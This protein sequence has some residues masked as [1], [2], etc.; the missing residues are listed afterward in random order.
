MLA[1]VIEREDFVKLRTK[2]IKKTMVAS[3]NLMLLLYDFAWK[4]DR[5]IYTGFNF[6]KYQWIYP[7]SYHYLRITRMLRS[8]NLFGLKYYSSRFLKALEAVYRQYPNQIGS[9]IDYWRAA[10][11]T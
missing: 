11:K 6:D 5:I 7:G 2:E 1:P 9:S 10:V 4:N 3:F 8:L